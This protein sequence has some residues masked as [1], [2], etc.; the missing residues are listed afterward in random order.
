MEYSADEVQVV[1]SHRYVAG[2]TITPVSPCAYTAV[3]WF[4]WRAHVHVN[5]RI[6]L[7][8]RLLFNCLRRRPMAT[9]ERQRA[10]HLSP[11]AS[12]WRRNKNQTEEITE[13]ISVGKK[14]IK[15][16][17]RHGALQEPCWHKLLMN[18]GKNKNT[19]SQFYC[20]LR[21]ILHFNEDKF[22]PSEQN[23]TF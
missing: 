6:E 17:S 13:N 1:V 20:F 14:K 12:P 11:H 2:N 5:A 7:P 18:V 16:L 19:D 4:D 3:T 9:G 21:L 10:E 15:S 8:V 22:Q 23:V